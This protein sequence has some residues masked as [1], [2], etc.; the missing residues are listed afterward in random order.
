MVS[1]VKKG[2]AWIKRLRVNDT[3]KGT[4]LKS[5]Q[6]ADSFTR[7]P[8]GSRRDAGIGIRGANAKE[9]LRAVTCLTTSQG[10]QA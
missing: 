10:D 6:T 7:I 1:V 9:E 5:W 4:I 8:Y 3:E 2:N